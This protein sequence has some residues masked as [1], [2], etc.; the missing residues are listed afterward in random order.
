MQRRAKYEQYI[1]EALAPHL[2]IIRYLRQ[3]LQP[4]G[5]VDKNTTFLI[6][7]L[8]MTSLAAGKETSSHPL[9][10]E[11]R[12]ELVLLALQLVREGRLPQRIQSALQIATYKFAL[13]WYAHTPRQLCFE[14]H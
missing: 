10:R 12:L 11:G 13:S 7:R 14:T 1:Q 5:A 8:V 6:Y 9:A 3:H 4:C 2:L